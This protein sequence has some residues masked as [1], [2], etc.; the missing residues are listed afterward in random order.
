MLKFQGP[1]SEKSSHARLL[2]RAVK[3][4]G[5][6]SFKALYEVLNEIDS[7]IQAS[8]RLAKANTS[9]YLYFFGDKAKE[10]WIGREL[11]GFLSSS[12]KNFKVFDSFRGEVLS[13]SLEDNPVGDL[14]LNSFVHHSEQLKGLAGESLASTWRVKIGP[15]E[16]FKG[17]KAIK[18][19]QITFQ[20]FKTH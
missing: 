7:F 14:D 1:Y 4:D 15:V 10:Y 11:T 8:P 6:L 16:D 2:Y 20:F 19:P 18:S 17:E 13:W 5:P 9:A 3:M 12:E